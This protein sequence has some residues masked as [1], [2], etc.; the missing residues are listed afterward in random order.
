MSVGSFNITVNKKRYGYNEVGKLIEE[1]FNNIKTITLENEILS[2]HIKKIE[3]DVDVLKNENIALKHDM[4][5]N[6]EKVINEYEKRL[7]EISEKEKRYEK[8]FEITDKITKKYSI[9]I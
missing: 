2:N 7:H 6:C 4:K 8:E 1:M 5:I 3:D 9:K